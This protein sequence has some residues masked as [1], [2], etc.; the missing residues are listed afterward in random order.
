MKQAM[1]TKP[2]EFSIQR[3]PTPDINPDQIRIQV[4]YTGICGSDIHAYYGEHP[5]ISCPIVLGHESSGKVIEIGKNVKKFCVGDRVV[6]RPQIVCNKCFLCKNGRYNICEHLKVIG[7]QVDGTC[8][9]YFVADE[10]LFYKL[11]E[12]I[13]YEVGS[14]V[15]P[16][17]VSVHAIYRGLEN[18]TGKK[19]LVIGAG[20][21]GNLLAQSALALG[22]EKVMIT[23]ISESKIDIAQKCGLKCFLNKNSSDIEES[24]INYFGPDG[25]DVIY[26]CSAN[27]KALNQAL[28]FARKGINIVIVG[29]YS[30]N[31]AVNV[32][33][34]QDRE[35]SVKGSL[36]Y[37]HED[38][39]EA[40]RLLE[41]GLI[42]AEVLLTRVF[43]IED[44]NNAYKY[45]ESNRDEVLKVLLKM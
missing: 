10:G 16:L 23:D 11:P 29:V 45:I 17:A 5:F 22:A 13:S 12:N 18:V 42:N 24:I 33:N 26:E 40:I 31:P 19:I 15:E 39:L 44:I 8:A 34:I 4:K 20:A 27:P 21:I 36:M 28:S 7:C 25:M 14:L 9:E 37:T 38:Y 6:L 41:F 43:N 30:A 1:L 3:V 32:A 35:Y 2:G